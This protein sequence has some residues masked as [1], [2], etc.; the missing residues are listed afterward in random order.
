MGILRTVV[1]PVLVGLAVA[2]SPQSAAATEYRVTTVTHCAH[3]QCVMT[4]TTYQLT[5]N[6]WV[7]SSQTT[8]TYK[9][10]DTRQEP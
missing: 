5:V 8:V 4:Q 1:A 6:G 2:G 7:I 10:G 3:G 9:E